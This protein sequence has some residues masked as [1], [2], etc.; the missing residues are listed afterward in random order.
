[1]AGYQG[2][3]PQKTSGLDD[4]MREFYQILKG[5]LDYS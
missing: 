5:Y 2:T 4:F 3:I 1:M